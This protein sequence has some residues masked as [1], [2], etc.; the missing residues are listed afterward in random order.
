[1]RLD[2]VEGQFSVTRCDF[3]A[4]ARFDIA[5][6]QFF[7]ERIFEISFNRSAHRTR[8]VSWIVTFFN[9]E[10]MRRGIEHNLDL[11]RL[12]SGLHLGDLKIDNAHQMRF[13]E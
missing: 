7:R 8:A 11:F 3:D 4:V 5:S 1:M 6:E 2:H 13:F 9:Y 12:N 10:L